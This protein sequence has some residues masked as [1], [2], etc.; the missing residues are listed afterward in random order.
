MCSL[1]PSYLYSCLQIPQTF[2][3]TFKWHY[4]I[5]VELLIFYLILFLLPFCYVFLWGIFLS[6]FFPPTS[7]PN[8]KTTLVRLSFKLSITIHLVTSCEYLFCSVIT[9]SSHFSLTVGIFGFIL[10]NFSFSLFK[11]SVTL[12]LTILC[13]FDC[14][15]FESATLF[16]CVQFV[17]KNKVNFNLSFTIRAFPCSLLV[18]LR[19]KKCVHYV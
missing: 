11:S 7:S 18:C 8:S 4:L 2:S 12:H 10:N 1:L 6:F 19:I 15:L 17:S 13:S 14:C 5:S 16:H 9:N 3:H